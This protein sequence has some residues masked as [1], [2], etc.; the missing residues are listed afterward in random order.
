MPRKNVCAVERADAEMYLKDVEPMWRAFWFHM[1]LVAKNLEEFAEGMTAISDEVFAYHV[2][3]QK[4]D[5]ERW[6]REVI[7][8][9][10][11]ANE[12]EEVATKEDAAHIVAARVKELKATLA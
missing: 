9:A 2:S 6:A 11:L 1:H 7:G 3:G 12:L 5:F 10:S 4:N 8:D